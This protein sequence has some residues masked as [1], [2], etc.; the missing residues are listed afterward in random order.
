MDLRQNILIISSMK[1]RI[2]NLT[3]SFF[4][5][6]NFTDTFEMFEKLSENTAIPI[7][8][9]SDLKVLFEWCRI[10]NGE[11]AIND[12]SKKNLLDSI[13]IVDKLIEYQIK[14]QI[15]VKH[16]DPKKYVKEFKS[17]GVLGNHVKTGVRK[18]IGVLMA[19]KIEFQS[20]IFE[21]EKLTQYINFYCSIIYLSDNLGSDT[22]KV[23]YNGLSNFLRLYSDFHKENVLVQE[24]M[25]KAR[26][27]IETHKERFKSKLIIR[28]N[29]SPVESKQVNKIND[30]QKNTNPQKNVVDSSFSIIDSEYSTPIKDLNRSVNENKNFSRVI[31]NKK[32]KITENDNI[33][34][35]VSN[36]QYIQGLNGKET[37]MIDIT[38]NNLNVSDFNSFSPQSSNVFLLQMEI[39]K[40]HQ[41]LER[42][43][44][45]MD[46]L[47]QEIKKL[48]EDAVHSKF[49]N[50]YYHPYNCS[51]SP[52]QNFSP[53]QHFNNQNNSFN[54]DYKNPQN[55]KNQNR[56]F[57]DPKKV[58]KSEFVDEIVEI[59]D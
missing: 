32:R 41:K 23:Y 5:T 9:L 40:L 33:Q 19:Y 54:F 30:S 44:N 21:S 50:N 45:E 53:Q 13:V 17:L 12:L 28:N 7:I 49:G 24:K 38:N 46:L 16:Y 48:K 6:N 34:N 27:I 20:D 36:S 25:T 56:G 4:S 26:D 14:N 1:K 55:I 51:Y 35:N 18:L 31:N 57:L 42:K 43:N 11:I 22:R 47:K 15:K 58:V 37:L 59:I 8:F 10:K 29:T 39:R 2:K 3:E 52:Q